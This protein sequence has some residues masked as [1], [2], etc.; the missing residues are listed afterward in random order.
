MKHLKRFENYTDDI[1]IGDYVVIKQDTKCAP[2]Y[3][4]FLDNPCK[5]VGLDNLNNPAISIK[6]ECDKDIIVWGIKNIE[7]HSKN[8]EDVEKELEII[9]NSKKYNL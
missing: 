8:K 6:L 9:K 5:V 2:Q 1:K 7:F 3:K 4:Y